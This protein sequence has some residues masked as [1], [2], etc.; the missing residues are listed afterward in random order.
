MGDPRIVPEAYEKA[1]AIPDAKLIS[2]PL[3]LIH[4]M[5]DDNVVF[6]NSSELIATLQEGNR[7]FEMMLY[8]GQTHGVGGEN[9]S[10]HL[11][12]TIFRFLDAHGV[13]P[14]E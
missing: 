3:L 5:A 14:P 11:W 9:I 8:P 7:P 10:P 12:N 13:T 4:G 6:E 2:D 1:S